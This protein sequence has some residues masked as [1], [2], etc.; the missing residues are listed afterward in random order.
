M[1]QT[2][3]TVAVLS[4]SLET[5]PEDP[6]VAYR[7]HDPPFTIVEVIKTAILSVTLLPIRLVIFTFVAV[8]SYIG[9]SLLCI[10]QDAQTTTEPMSLRR[11]RLM[12]ALTWYAGA[13]GCLAFGLWIRVSN[14]RSIEC[15]IIVVNHLSYI[16]V[17]V[18][19]KLYQPSFVAKNSIQYV[20]LIG[21][22]AKCMQCMFLLA[23]R[24]NEEAC[25]TPATGL[26]Q[27]IVCRA[28]LN[29]M[30]PLVV[31]PEG[32]TTNGRELVRFRTGVFRC[33]QS[34]QPIALRYPYKHFSL[35]W[36]TIPLITHVWRLM[37]Q[38]VNY[39]E[40]MPLDKYTPSME[41]CANAYL[42]ADNL[43]S[44]IAA[45]LQ[46]GCSTTTSREHKMVYHDSVMKII[47]EDEALAKSAYLTRLE[48]IRREEG[49]DQVATSQAVVHK[50]YGSMR[51]SV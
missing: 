12:K 39:V 1:S 6:F 40:V 8:T 31:F 46:C 37:T 7:R 4:T 24:S 48:E 41:E 38:F 49:M 45:V 27:S 14:T 28:Q 16:D 3:S 44:T 26:T 21:A 43:Q 17:L 23:P 30:P 18:L 9:T 32:T 33:K 25:A 2:S 36:E 42:Y 20:P 13:G 11:R 35:T 10:G 19:M 29:D 51:V 47:S 50:S 5:C 34:I 22:I 15:P